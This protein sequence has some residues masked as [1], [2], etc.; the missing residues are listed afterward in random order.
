M[1]RFST[2]SYWREK[3]EGP[4][5]GLPVAISSST[6]SDSSKNLALYKG[7]SIKSRK[8]K[9]QAALQEQ[10]MKKAQKD[11]SGQASSVSCSIAEAGPVESITTRLR[12]EIIALETAGKYLAAAQGMDRLLKILDSPT[13]EDLCYALALNRKAPF[14]Q[15]RK[16][17]THQLAKLID[18][19]LKIDSQA[20]EIYFSEYSWHQLRSCLDYLVEKTAAD[21]ACELYQLKYKV[22]GEDIVEH[23]QWLLAH[24]RSYKYPISISSRNYATEGNKSEQGVW[25][26]YKKELSIKN[27]TQEELRTKSFPYLFHGGKLDT[28]YLNPTTFYNLMVRAGFQEEDFKEGKHGFQDKVLVK[29]IILT[30]T[31]LNECHEEL[32][33]LINSTLKKAKYPYITFI[34]SLHPDIKFNVNELYSYDSNT[35]NSLARYFFYELSSSPSTIVALQENRLYFCFYNTKQATLD[36]HHATLKEA[37]DKVKEFIVKRYNKFES[38]CTIITGRGNHVNSDVQRGILHQEFRKWAQNE[39]KPYI[40]SYRA[41]SANGCYKVKLKEPISLLLIDDPLNPNVEQLVEKIMEAEQTNNKRLIIKHQQAQLNNCRYYHELVH[42]T[43]VTLHERYKQNLP[44]II[45]GYE[46]LSTSNTNRED[47]LWISWGK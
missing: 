47:G 36:L 28:T 21:S 26:V 3:N 29:P 44:S 25:D 16:N 32:R 22:M 10:Q 30:K 18:K 20:S 42:K 34:F 40:E 15:Q 43:W 35:L 13:F 24:M 46:E 45:D 4:Q 7:K 33:E 31:K 27:Y 6:A 17:R 14:V 11:T 8:N 5:V 39:L 2:V 9:K 38:E 12:A 1:P 41:T 23:M 19:H 37:F